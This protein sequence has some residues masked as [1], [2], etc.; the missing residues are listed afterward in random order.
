MEGGQ[1]IL[2]ASEV[3]SKQKQLKITKEKAEI[4]GYRAEGT[5]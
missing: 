1:M 5:I 4:I 3:L 2:D